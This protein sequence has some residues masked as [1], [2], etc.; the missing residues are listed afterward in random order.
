M[1][2]HHII[3]KADGG[4]DTY[5]NAIPL[6]FNCHADMGKTD[7][8]HPKGREYTAE[9]LKIHR[10][11]WYNLVESG[12]ALQGL[13]REIT[14]NEEEKEYL[15]R[16]RA[17]RYE[18]SCAIDYYANVYTDIVE[19][20]DARHENA[21]DDLRKIGVMIKAFA[22]EEQPEC[23]TVPKVADLMEIG[24]LFIGL[25]NNMYI[26]KG[27]DR[28]AYLDCNLKWEGKI[29]ELLQL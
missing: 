27:G 24:G 2:I 8:H 1:E 15:K 4:K 28:N 23:D 26:H 19:E 5:E 12:Q 13:P 7:P 20:A 29:R 22:T 6:C 14:E 3:H 9:E 11:R 21:S 10:D 25:S 16:Y 18:A 17:L